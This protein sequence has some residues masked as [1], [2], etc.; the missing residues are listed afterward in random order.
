MRYLLGCLALPFVLLAAIIAWMVIVPDGDLML[1]CKVIGRH[2]LQAAVEVDGRQFSGEVTTVRREERFQYGRLFTWDGCHSTKG[3]AIAI[4]V[5]G[6][7][8][9]L[10]PANLCEAA[11]Q[12]LD[13]DGEADVR[14][15]CH[16]PERQAFLRSRP[17]AR[18]NAFIV[19]GADA[20][21]EWRHLWYGDEGIELVRLQAT[22]K[23]WAGAEDNIEQVAPAMLVTQFEDDGSWTS[24]EALFPN[25][26]RDGRADEHFAAMEVAAEEA[27]AD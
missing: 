3:R 2:H 5:P 21:R 9:V 4:R 15:I 12:A 11:R 8:V 26:R 23:W 24:P 10:V 25:S 16:S 18:G 6:D 14:A 22:S 13:D 7:R 27:P 19:H 20:P 1:G 17:Q